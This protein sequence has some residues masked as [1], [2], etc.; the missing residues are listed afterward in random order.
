MVNSVNAPFDNPE[1][2]LDGVGCDAHA[3]FVAYILMSRV[4]H[5]AV[6]VLLWNGCQHRARI[7]H[8][9]GRFINGLFD[10]R[11]QVFGSDAL[12]MRG[13]HVSIPLQDRNDDFLFGVRMNAFRARARL[14][15]LPEDTLP[16]LGLLFSKLP[17][18]AR[19]VLASALAAEVAFIDFNDTGQLASRWFLSECP[20]NAMRHEPRRL[21]A[22]LLFAGFFVNAPQIT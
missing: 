9:V 11:S 14:P 5:L 12:H 13:S 17:S 16:D 10:H 22:A 4:I 18:A 2:A 20:A 21:I 19:I 7:R 15:L 3:V 6:L 1:V 8:N